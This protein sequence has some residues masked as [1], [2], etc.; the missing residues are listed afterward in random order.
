MKNLLNK[1]LSLF[2]TAKKPKLQIV[3]MSHQA[4]ADDLNGMI[5]PYGN[6]PDESTLL[7]LETMYRGVFEANCET[8]PN[9][10]LTEYGA[11]VIVSN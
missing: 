5:H 3:K 2:K 10:E 1:I 11:I 7:E 4:V 9:F 6:K 8:L